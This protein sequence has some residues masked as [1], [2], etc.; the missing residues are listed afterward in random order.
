MRHRA[1]PKPYDDLNVT[2]LLDLAWNLLVIFVIMATATVQ[3]ITV[4]L[5][6]A[7]AAP[8]LGKPKTRAVTV[9]ADGRVYLDTTQVTLPELEDKLRQLRAA[10]PDLPVV[11]KGDANVRYDDVVHVLDVIKRVDIT[12]LGLATRRFVK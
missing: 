11:V 7:S 8:N 6:K 2:P 3:G 10:S 5:P 1:R 12:N 4:A 9:L